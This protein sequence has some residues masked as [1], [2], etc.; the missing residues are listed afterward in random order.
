MVFGDDFRFANARQYFSSLD[1]LI[2]GFNA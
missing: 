1:K 2:K